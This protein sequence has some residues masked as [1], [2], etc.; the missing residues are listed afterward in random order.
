MFKLFFAS[1]FLADETTTEI[2][3][4]EEIIANII[5]WLSTEGVKLLIGAIVLFIVFKI[6]NLIARRFKKQMENNYKSCL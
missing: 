6:I 1:L 4:L 3:N 5:S 2:I